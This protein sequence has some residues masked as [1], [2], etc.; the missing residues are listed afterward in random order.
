[1]P[2]ALLTPELT[3]KTAQK[4]LALLI[5]MGCQRNTLTATDTARPVAA[6]SALLLMED[7]ADLLSVQTTRR[8]HL[9]DSA[10]RVA[11]V[12][13]VKLRDDAVR[14]TAATSDRLLDLMAAASPATTTAS[15]FKE[16]A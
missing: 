14:L 10:S 15:H 3:E 2:S 13:E 9:T 1:M 12:V 7:L 4:L 5:V 6:T 8:L 11:D 16:L